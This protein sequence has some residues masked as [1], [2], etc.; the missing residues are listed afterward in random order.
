MQGTA[1]WSPDG[2]WIVTGG[3]DSQGEGL[4][5][6]PTDGGA[7]VRVVKGNFDQS[8]VVARGEF[9]HVH[10]QERRDPCTFARRAA[11]WR[12]SAFARDHEYENGGERYRF[13]PD[14]KSLIYMQGDLR[15][16]NFWALE[17]A[18][19]KTHQLTDLRNRATMRTFDVTADGKQIVF[20]RLL[21][22]SDV[23]LIDLPRRSVTP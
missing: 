20:D 10:G 4:F 23:V 6:I 19:K 12:C 7:P 22:N 11:R 3:S 2:K 21:E 14:G 18:S 5:K 1:G 15:S 16:Q 17:L 9:D 8:G 13:L